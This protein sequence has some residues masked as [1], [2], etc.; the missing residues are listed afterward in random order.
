MIVKKTLYR[1]KQQEFNIWQ[2]VASKMNSS[3]TNLRGIKK[4]RF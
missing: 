1:L 4:L 2:I 3:K